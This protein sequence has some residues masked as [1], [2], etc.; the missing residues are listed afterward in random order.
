MKPAHTLTI[1]GPD[2]VVLTLP[3][4]HTG[5]SEVERTAL[6][7]LVASGDIN[8]LDASEKSLLAGKKAF[9]RS[10]GPEALIARFDLT[11]VRID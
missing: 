6:Q 5:M 9:L 7:K 11:F 1:T 4:D 2:G 3:V 8:T 10:G